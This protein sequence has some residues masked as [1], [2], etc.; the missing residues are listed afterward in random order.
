MNIIKLN[1]LEKQSRNWIICLTLLLANREIEKG[2]LYMQSCKILNSS[3]LYILILING[4]SLSSV[5]KQIISLQANIALILCFLFMSFV[6]VNFDPKCYNFKIVSL[7]EDLMVHL[8]WNLL[9]GFWPLM[10]PYIIIRNCISRVCNNEKKNVK[11]SHY[12]YQIQFWF[13]KVLQIF[14]SI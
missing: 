2:T 10:S 7:V 6:D 8:W 13:T 5:A 4:W 11:F 14:I 9:S 1:E 3:I 12:H